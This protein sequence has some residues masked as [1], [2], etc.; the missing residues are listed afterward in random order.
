MEFEYKKI[1]ADFKFQYSLNIK[2]S[3]T[4]SLLFFLI[5]IHLSPDVDLAPQE[6]GSPTVL[7]HVEDIPMTRQTYRPP[8]PPKPA[9]PI[10]SDDESIPEEETIEETTLKYT[11]FEAA[12]TPIPGI[13]LT[14][15]K[16]I[17]WVFP[18]F[19]EEEK[20]KG[21]SGVVKLSLNIN[22]QGKV[23]N[24]IVMDNTTGSEK[25]AQA[26]VEAAYGSRFFPAKE[27]N[28]PVDYWIS[29]PYRFDVKE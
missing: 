24:V 27:G 13:I 9:I 14:P 2:K 17:A 28:K 19:P 3:L 25:C 1:K 21:V 7:I 18:E 5:V 22:E 6:E 23:I 15:P 20:K 12:A 11:I 8:P 26:A 10:P 29:Q 4:L 16:P